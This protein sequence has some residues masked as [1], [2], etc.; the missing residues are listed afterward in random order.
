M[1][2]K[3]IDNLINIRTFP[4]KQWEYLMFHNLFLPSWNWFLTAHCFRVPDDNSTRIFFVP[5]A[6]LTAKY[7]LL[8]WLNKSR[9]WYSFFAGLRVRFRFLCLLFYHIIIILSNEVFPK[10]EVLEKPQIFI[11]FYTKLIIQKK[12][13]FLIFLDFLKQICKISSCNNFIG[14]YGCKKN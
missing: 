12:A 13:E 7:R 10:L 9:H 11:Y 5:S 8:I 6:V 3:L 1:I 2:R 14:I 4:G